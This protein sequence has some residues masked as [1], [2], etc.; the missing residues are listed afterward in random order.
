[1]ALGVVLAAASTRCGYPTFVFDSNGGAG[2]TSSSHSSSHS[3]SSH[4]SSGTG[5]SGSNA[6]QV[7][8][9]ATD[10]GPTGR[11]T[12]ADVAKGALQCV[13]LAAAP[14]SPYAACP[15]GDGDCPAG[16]W[17][18]RR[19]KVCMP[20]C[21]PGGTACGGGGSCVA[22]SAGTAPVPGDYVCTAHCEPISAS[23]CRQ[24][25]T[26]VYDPKVLD[27]DC[28]ESGNASLSGSCTL[29]YDC[30]KGLVCGVDQTTMLGSCLLWCSPTQT[31]SCPSF[32]FCNDFS[33]PIS[34][35]GAS[36]GYCG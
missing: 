12:I 10:C 6:C 26:C 2:G 22:A 17:C 11:C 5:G 35:S 4:S 3:S 14:L 23:P 1:M 31:S 20:F 8:H 30:G 18:D 34:Y 28:F 25:A 13:P 21:T 29:P 36:Y 19:T 27:F 15:K 9:D 7:L 24:G 33:S 32:G 16:T